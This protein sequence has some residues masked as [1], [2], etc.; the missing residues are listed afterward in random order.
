MKL[1]YTLAAL[2]VLAVTT[3][4][5]QAVITNMKDATAFAQFYLGNQMWENGTP[6]YVGDWN[7]DIASGGTQADYSNNGTNLV[8]S[9]TTNNGWFQHD[10]DTSPWDLLLPTESW[11]AEMRVHVQSTPGGVSLWGAQIGDGA[12]IITVNNNGVSAGAGA[13]LDLDTTD[14]TDGFHTFR[15][16][17]DGPDGVYSVWRDGALLTSTQTATLNLGFSRFI[18]GDCCSS[19]GGVGNVFE[20]EYAAYDVTGAFAPVLVPEPSSTALL[21]LGGLALLLRRRK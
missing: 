7:G 14:N 1:K 12:G 4:S 5:A 8:V 11:T 10:N 19:Y 21:G 2:A 13:A 17:Y 6:A 9:Q 15:L 16:A 3:L 18:I 20:I